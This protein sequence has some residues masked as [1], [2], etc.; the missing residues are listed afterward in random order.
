MRLNAMHRTLLPL[1]AL[2]LLPACA[3]A[4]TPPA[5]IVE[6]ARLKIVEAVT[7]GA[8]EEEIK[9][10]PAWMLKTAPEMFKP[11]DINGD[12]FEHLGRGLE[13]PGRD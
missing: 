4:A 2:A 11:V 10:I 6:E 9:E 13:H 3:D 8:T 5:A 7:S 12:R 1:L